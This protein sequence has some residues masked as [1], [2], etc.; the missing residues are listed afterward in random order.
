MKVFFRNM[1]L[2]IKLILIFIY[3]INGFFMFSGIAKKNIGRV[4]NSM[5]KFYDGPYIVTNTSAD[6]IKLL[7]S[8]EK[9]TFKALA[10]TFAEDRFP[11]EYLNEIEKD[12]TLL[13][14]EVVILEEHFLENKQLIKDF[15]NIMD[16]SVQ[17]KEEILQLFK[18][19]KRQEALEV[20]NTK[21]A[22]TLQ[23]A[24]GIL[25]NIHQDAQNQAE[26]LYEEAKDIEKNVTM[27]MHLVVFINI[28]F[29]TLIGVVMYRS[30]VQPIEHIEKE[31][32]KIIQ[33]DLDINIQYSSKN[34][35]GNL[36]SS[37]NETMTIIKSY[38][39]NISK[40]LKE[41]ADG[42]MT[43]T[44]DIEYIGD[45]SPIKQSMQQILDSLNSLLIQISISSRQVTGTASNLS[46]A[47][48]F[49]A[50]GVTQQEISIRQLLNTI[51]DMSEQIKHTNDFAQES[52]IMVDN[53]V[54]AVQ[55]SDAQMKEMLNTMA[56]IKDSSSKIEN[57]IK[58]IEDIAYQTNILA[59]NASIE[60]ER[61]GEFGK[62]FSVVANKVRDLAERSSQAVKSTTI[63]IDA[64]EQ[65]VQKGVKIANATAKSLS[66]VVSDVNKITAFIE[67]IYTATQKQSIDIEQITQETEQ[68]SSVVQTN[69]A[70]SQQSAASS[71]ELLF[72]AE[73]LKKLVEQFKLRE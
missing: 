26:N 37:I 48:E 61:A 73:N 43:A 30:I 54:K 27:R 60:A 72:Q 39:R 18:D 7:T 46:E 34:E 14:E 66:S 63:I 53:A 47:S 13:K 16:S 32:S 55:F 10:L 21:Y 15:I 17:H 11:Q 62:G 6:S 68:I 2:S 19:N 23:K 42:D 56:E 12:I 69:C 57:V 20:L 1:K 49:L 41:V 35:I 29:M 70:T 67:H 31:A 71:E 9:N 22:P 59:L 36:A 58:T 52:T 28:I 44:V 65:S 38:I 25:D 51:S 8:I 33:G 5:N 4:A 40:I 64:S 24:S 45:F 3:I 50:K